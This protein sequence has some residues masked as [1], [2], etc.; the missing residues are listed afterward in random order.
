[1]ETG[2]PQSR[3]G[4]R[5][6]IAGTHGTN[7]A[8]TTFASATPPSNRARTAHSA[9]PREGTDTD[10]AVTA[11]ESTIAT[12]DAAI[13]A[14]GSTIATTDTRKGPTIA[15]AARRTIDRSAGSS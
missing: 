1:M 15:A 8:I 13:T 3:G 14:R 7:R 6:E 2:G 5:A 11:R 9:P 10:A 4:A 12:T